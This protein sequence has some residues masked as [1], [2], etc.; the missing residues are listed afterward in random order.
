R[1]RAKLI[2][3][4]RDL[5]D[6]LR[7]YP[8]TMD[9][10]PARYARAIG[11]YRANQLDKAFAELD[12]LLAE[13]PD[14]PYF[15]ELKGQILYEH[16]KIEEAVPYY[17]RSV[18]PAPDQPMLQYGLAQSLIALE[19]PDQDQRAIAALNKV[20]QVERGN[21]G[22]WRLLTVAYGR[23]G[24]LGMAALAQAEASFSRRE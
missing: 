6:V 22:A 16:G 4:L 15:I 12:G 14:D 19:R 17:D 21:Y 10:V 24:D 11:Y 20:I 1:M 13:F 3:F 2:G 9:T 7:D 23:G 8:E 5:P 18:A